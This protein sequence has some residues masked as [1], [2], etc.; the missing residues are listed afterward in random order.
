MLKFNYGLMFTVESNH[1]SALFG[2]DAFSEVLSLSMNRLMIHIDMLG[3]AAGNDDD[4]AASNLNEI[5]VI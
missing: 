2:W 4:I 3:D 5:M 1:V